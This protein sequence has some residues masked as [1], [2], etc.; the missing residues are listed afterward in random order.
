MPFSRVLSHTK[1]ANALI[2][3]HFKLFSQS[4]CD[5]EPLLEHINELLLEVKEKINDHKDFFSNNDAG[6]NS[7]DD[8]NEKEIGSMDTTTWVEY[9]YKLF[10]CKYVSYNN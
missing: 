8:N 4:E 5:D 9:V 6:E 10:L 2:H 7:E 1:S 3:L